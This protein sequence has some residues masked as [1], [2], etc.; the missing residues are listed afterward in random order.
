VVRI[1]G[2][3]G[4]YF[5]VL[6]APSPDDPSQTVKVGV[7]NDTFQ[8][9]RKHGLVTSIAQYFGIVQEGLAETQHLFRGLERPLMHD[10]D[11]DADER[12]LVYAWRPYCDYEW[13][14]GPWDGNIIPREPPPNRV[15]V[16]LVKE[17]KPNE[18]G[19]YGS[20][21][22]WNWIMEDSRLKDAPVEWDVRY[23]KK[24]WSKPR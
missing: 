2:R 7:R 9:Y 16:V 24:L 23:G 17:E 5:E 19:V 13:S 22:K 18:F 12:V 20:I 10:A 3:T 11:M 4:P 6:A 21:E 1:A 8:R 14:G 15:F